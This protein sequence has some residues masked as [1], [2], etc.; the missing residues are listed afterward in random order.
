MLVGSARGITLYALVLSHLAFSFQLAGKGHRGAH[1]SHQMRFRVTGAG[2]EGERN[3]ITE[4]P[5]LQS[6]KAGLRANRGAP[7][8]LWA[9]PTDQEREEQTDWLS[10]SSES[11]SR[12]G[13]LW[14]VEDMQAPL[15]PLHSQ[16][17]CPQSL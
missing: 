13:R 11:P 4:R 9:S 7:G 1:I 6:G 16:S 5:T 8:Q 15:P 2:G 10:D 17:S 3:K 12:R 14:K